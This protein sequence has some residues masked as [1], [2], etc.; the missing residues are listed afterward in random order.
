M[1]LQ[2]DNAYTVTKIFFQNNI[3][4]IKV[5]LNLFFKVYGFKTI[6][7][8]DFLLSECLRKGD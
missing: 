5:N 6:F 8:L 4:P 1:A 3:W 2:L 7:R